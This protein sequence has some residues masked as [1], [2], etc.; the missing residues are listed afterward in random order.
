MEERKRHAPVRRRGRQSA[1]SSRRRISGARRDDNHAAGRIPRGS[2][3]G[4]DITS[5]EKTEELVRNHF[6]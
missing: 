2:G 1:P 3:R 5:T 4:E 6:S